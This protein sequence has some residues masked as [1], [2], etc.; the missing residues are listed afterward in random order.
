MKL[1]D[2]DGIDEQDKAQGTDGGDPGGWGQAGDELQEGYEQE[3]HV[4]HSGELLEEVDRQK[5]E[6]SVLGCSD[7]VAWQAQRI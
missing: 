5:G 3:V 6:Q 7:A 2:L 4:G 1:A